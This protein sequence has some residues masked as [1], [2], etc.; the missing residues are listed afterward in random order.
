[1]RIQRVLNNNVV[2]AHD[3]S[4][5]ECVV[6]GKGVGFNKKASDLVDDACIQKIFRLD[7]DNSFGKANDAFQDV[8]EALFDIVLEIVKQAT[9][10]LDRK[11]HK[12]V[13]AS[14]LDHISFAIERAK[15][16]VHVRNML[17]WDIK[18]LYRNEFI[19]GVAALE[20]IKK[21]LN[22]ELAEDEA[23]FI[24]LHL[25][26]SQKDGTM[27]DIE[28]VSKV[29]Q[30]ILNIVKYHFNIEYE[31][32]SINFQRFVTHLKFFSHRLL[33]NTYVST[34]DNSLHDIVAEK[35]AISYECAKKINKFIKHEYGRSLTD[36]E[37]MFLS[38]HIE[39]VRKPI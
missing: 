37:M 24:A 8:P 9:T 20:S 21:N 28:N 23:G 12:S 1:M 13:Y 16:G 31:E 32:E 38:I 5:K 17:L 7:E 22:I 10:Q 26:N 36:D 18:R 15:Q 35:Y 29:I 6:I 33:S 2:V 25:L 11:I 27:P 19:I 3:F 34:D 14:L 30:D 4:G 39:H